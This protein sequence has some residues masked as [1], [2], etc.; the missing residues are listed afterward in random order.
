MGKETIFIPLSKTFKTIPER[1]ND[2]KMTNIT[3]TNVQKEPGVW[4]SRNKGVV[5]YDKEKDFLI[6]KGK[7]K[8]TLFV[9]TVGLTVP[10][11]YLKNKNFVEL[12]VAGKGWLSFKFI[13]S[14]ITKNGVSTK[15]GGSWKKM[16]T[17]REK[18]L[19]LTGGEQWKKVKININKV[20]NKPFNVSLKAFLYGLKKVKKENIAALEIT[21]RCGRVQLKKVTFA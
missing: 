2:I 5:S 13:E 21:L 4:Y 3:D 9:G 11:D 1:F 17:V 7:K 16:D 18:E 8:F 10:K 15:I 20:R 12:T 19:L 14:T 6:I